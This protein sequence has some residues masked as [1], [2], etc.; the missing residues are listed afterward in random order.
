MTQQLVDPHTI[1][2]YVESIE[3]MCVRLSVVYRELDTVRDREQKAAAAAADQ[4]QRERDLVESLR[5][6][7]RGLQERVAKLELTIAITRSQ[8]RN[9]PDDKIVEPT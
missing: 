6:Q 9:D 5:D 4:L 8:R 3:A 2:T 7:V 1:R